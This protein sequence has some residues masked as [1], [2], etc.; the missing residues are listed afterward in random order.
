MREPGTHGRARKH[1]VE[2]AHALSVKALR[3]VIDARRPG[4]PA[5][6][7]ARRPDGSGD[8]IEV[9]VRPLRA[10]GREIEV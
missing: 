6:V 1:L 5:L 9:R 3:Q 4:G 10:D 2:N 7:A 8:M